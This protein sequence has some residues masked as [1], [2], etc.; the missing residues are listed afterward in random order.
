L[1]EYFRHKKAIYAK[2][3]EKEKENIGVERDK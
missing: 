2:D 3:S 1:L